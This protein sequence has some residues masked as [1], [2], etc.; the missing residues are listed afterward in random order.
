LAG[1]DNVRRM[2]SPAS[3]MEEVAPLQQQ[4][5]ARVSS[6]RQR[7]AGEAFNLDGPFSLSPKNHQTNYLPDDAGQLSQ[8]AENPI[9]R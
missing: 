6:H 8:R 1:R 3:K 4:V 5:A 2:T 9:K 7:T